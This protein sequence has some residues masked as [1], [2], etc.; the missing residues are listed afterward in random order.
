MLDSVAQASVG[1]KGLVILSPDLYNPHGHVAGT[2]EAFQNI[3]SLEI[4]QRCSTDYY[5]AWHLKEHQE[6]DTSKQ[7]HV[8]LMYCCMKATHIRQPWG[9]PSNK[10]VDDPVPF[11]SHAK[12]L[13]AYLVAAARGGLRGEGDV[14]VGLH[15]VPID[16]L[17][18]R[19][20]HA[21]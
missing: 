20:S 18:A 11:C 16:P 3:H 9:L 12:I 4:W 6:L 21:G 19:T 17:D 8:V 13:S 1:L 7:E 5:W 2:S 10:A 14:R 15:S